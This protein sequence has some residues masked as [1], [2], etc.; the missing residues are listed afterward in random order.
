MLDKMMK[1][2]KIQ[3]QKQQKQ[4]K[5]KVHDN[6]KIKLLTQ[7]MTSKGARISKV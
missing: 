1:N 3:D 5:E 6:K 7:W 2:K 4:K